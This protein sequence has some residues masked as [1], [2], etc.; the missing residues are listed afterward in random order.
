MSR[1]VPRLFTSTYD[2][3][4]AFRSSSG[5]IRITA[6]EKTTST[7]PCRSISVAAKRSAL[8][9]SATSNG[10][11]RTSAR[12]RRSPDIASATR[13]AFLPVR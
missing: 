1:V 5:V 9:G 3:M 6:F 12:P 10:S 13:A 8:A 11:P 4:S 7:P 2:P